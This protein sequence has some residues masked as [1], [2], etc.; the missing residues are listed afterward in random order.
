MEWDHSIHKNIV[1]AFLWKIWEMIFCTK[2]EIN[3][4]RI[5]MDLSIKK[6]LLCWNFVLVENDV[7][8][9]Q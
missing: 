7:E 3:G 1:Q 8:T 5:G 4:Y 9:G 2:F 6:Y